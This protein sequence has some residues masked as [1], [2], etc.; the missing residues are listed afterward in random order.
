M[1]ASGLVITISSILER[2]ARKYFTELEGD[3]SNLRR[4]IAG[5]DDCWM[6]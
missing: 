6:Q 2:N 4:N 5:I 1:E 3:R